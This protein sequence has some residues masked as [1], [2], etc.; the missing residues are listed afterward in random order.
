MKTVNVAFVFDDKFSDLFM[1]AAYS[2]AKNTQFDLAIYIVDCGISEK[3]RK[4]ICEMLGGLTNVKSTQFGIPTRIDTF[5][6]YPIQGRFSSAIFYRLAI[7]EIFPTLDRVIYLDCDV[8]VVGDIADMWNEDLRC[9]ALGVVDERNF[10]VPGKRKI[11][12]GFTVLRCYFNSGVL[13]ID[14]KKFLASKIFERVLNLIHTTEFSLMYPEQDAMNLCLSCGEYA[15]LSPK[16]NFI[17]FGSVSKSTIK[18][19]KKPVIVHNADWK[20]SSF[21]RKVVKFLN[22]LLFF[23]DYRLR[24]VSEFWE[25]ANAV[26]PKCWGRQPVLNTLI[27]FIALALIGTCRCICD[28]FRGQRTPLKTERNEAQSIIFTYGNNE[29]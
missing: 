12:M 6:K 25:Y 24:M 17:P 10:H 21:N 14:Y 15:I 13:L 16:Y 4:R 18:A 20:P 11:A 8:V 1:V 28:F 29:L 22:A 27:F 7:P 5:E 2:A 23:R 26:C 9:R 3:N 19:I